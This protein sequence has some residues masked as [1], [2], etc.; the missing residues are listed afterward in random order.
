MLGGMTAMRDGLCAAMEARA[1]TEALGGDHEMRRT[2]GGCGAGKGESERTTQLV[3][4]GV[5]REA[6]SGTLSVPSVST[7]ITR[8]FW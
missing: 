1:T 7:F 3:A 8:R 5:R 4:L 6:R 2:R